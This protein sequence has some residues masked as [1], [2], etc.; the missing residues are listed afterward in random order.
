MNTR[1]K[2]CLTRG[3]LV[4]LHCA[5]ELRRLVY[6]NECNNNNSNTDQYRSRVAATCPT[7]LP[8][9]PPQ[10]N[11][12]LTRNDIFAD[13][14][15]P[16]I[17]LTMLILYGRCRVYYWTVRVGTESIVFQSYQS[18]MQTYPMTYFKTARMRSLMNLFALVRRMS[19]IYGIPVWEIYGG[20]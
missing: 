8:M 17:I 11:V 5:V 13:I 20:W 4:G 16:G 18:M 12:C 1:I 7:S 19:D 14:W 10:C 2:K 3:E 9:T 15:C 6:K